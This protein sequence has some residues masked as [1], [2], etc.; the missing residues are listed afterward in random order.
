MI[1]WL[2][3]GLLF[4]GLVVGTYAVNKMAKEVNAVDDWDEHSPYDE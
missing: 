3:F 2:G 4:L 1:G